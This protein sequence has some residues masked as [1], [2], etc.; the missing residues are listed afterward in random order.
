ME[1]LNKIPRLIIVTGKGGVGKTTSALAL[2]KSLKLQGHNVVY[3]T[4]QMGTLRRE[5]HTFDHQIIKNLCDILEITHESL[6]LKSCL[7]EYVTQK[8]GSSLIADWIVNTKFFMSL[9]EII[10]GFAQLIYMGRVLQELKLNPSMHYILDAAAT[11]HA[12][13]LVESI[14]NFHK[15]FTIGPLHQDMQ[16][17]KTL[18]T[19]ENFVKFLLITI[20]QELSIN[21]FHE[22]KKNLQEID[23]KLS[24][25]MNLNQCFAISDFPWDCIEKTQFWK[26]NLEQEKALA[27][28]I[29]DEFIKMPMIA[30]IDSVKLIT[31][32]SQKVDWSRSL[33]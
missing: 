22:L 20:P 26:N 6:V 28:R 13:T 29:G 3:L 24:C 9:V 16:M 2:T 1:Q 10:P 14:Y 19:S 31:E 7:T 30:N 8:L 17:L 32:L 18:F 15:I 27:N 23:S 4:L 25:S 5:G 21:E 12:L 33:T 11:G